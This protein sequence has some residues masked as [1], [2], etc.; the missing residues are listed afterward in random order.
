MEIWKNYIHHTKN[1]GNKF[2]EIDNIIDEVMTQK[3]SNFTMKIT[4]SDVR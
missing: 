3:I 4:S 2:W 1:E